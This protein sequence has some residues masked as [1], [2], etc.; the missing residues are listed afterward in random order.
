MSNE[1]P[2][3]ED[4]GDFNRGQWY[5]ETITYST[6]KY[7]TIPSRSYPSVRWGR[8]A[9]SKHFIAKKGASPWKD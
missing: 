6:P 3:L 8:Y 2:I 5:S 9:R 1:R 7:E 4:R